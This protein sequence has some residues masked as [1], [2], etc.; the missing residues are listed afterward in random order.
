MAKPRIEIDGIRYKWRH[1]GDGGA[2]RVVIRADEREDA[3]LAGVLI[4]ELQLPNLLAPYLVEHVIRRGLAEGWT[5]AQPGTRRLMIHGVL[6]DPASA[7]PAA[8]LDPTEDALLSLIVAAPEGD[9]DPRLVYADWLA[10]RG[11]PLGEYVALV[12]AAETRELTPDERA[13]LIELALERDGWLGPVGALVRDVRWARGLPVYAELAR[14]EYGRLAES[15]GARGWRLLRTLVCSG[16]VLGLPDQVSIVV[17]P[18]LSELRALVLTTPLANELAAQPHG[19]WP[20]LERLGLATDPEL[21]LGSSTLGELQARMPALRELVVPTPGVDML[22]HALQQARTPRLTI[23][24]AFTPVIGAARDLLLAH[25]RP[26]LE[27]LVF[28]LAWLGFD[29]PGPAVAIQRGQDGRWSTL[30]VA[31]QGRGEQVWRLQVVAALAALPEDAF[32]TIIHDRR[33]DPEAAPG[34]R[35]ELFSTARYEAELQAAFLRQRGAQVILWPRE[36]GGVP[37]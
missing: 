28:A 31:W 36:A 34:E 1:R 14:R 11:E 13:R 20:R 6:P 7:M 18:A 33:G 17:Q 16:H 4:G 27:E 8:A 19:R 26:E 9:P 35:D 25:A 37:R 29:A 32:S 22:S 30:V 10:A 15:L 24:G 2:Q 3:R 21:D 12:H 5:V 23:I